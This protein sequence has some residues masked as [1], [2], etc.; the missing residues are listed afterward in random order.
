MANR[1]MT[2]ETPG[3]RSFRASRRRPRATTSTPPGEL[4]VDGM[5][6]T[7]A[8]ANVDSHR[9]YERSGFQQRFVVY[10]GRRPGAAASARSQ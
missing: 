8:V 10:Y 7:T 9:F 6:I 2:E 4:G 3:Q 1:P 5:A